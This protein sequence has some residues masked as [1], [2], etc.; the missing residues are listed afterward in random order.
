MQCSAM[1]KTRER[2][3]N[4]K[5]VKGKT[6]CRMHGGKSLSGIASPTFKTGEHSKYLPARLHEKFNESYN[7]PR[8]RSLREEIAVT[9]TRIKE[10]MQRLGKDDGGELWALLVKAR[11][12]YT[13]AVLGKDTER[14]GAAIAD[15]TA[16][17]DRGAS[18]EATWREL[19]DAHDNLRRLL[20]TEMKSMVAAHQ[21]ITVERAMNMAASLA[22]VVKQNVT[23]R[24]ALSA[25]QDGFT[26]IFNVKDAAGE[27]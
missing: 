6:V 20:E 16:L 25:I 9:R 11:T 12:E 13:R 17:I 15:M 1:I 2:R 22:A 27:D 24:K 8:W 5:A 10:L 19:A 26:R 3:C 7:D 4:G 18:D 23:D 21:M 14:M